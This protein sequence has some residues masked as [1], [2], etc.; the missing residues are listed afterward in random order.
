MDHHICTLEEVRN[1]APSRRCICRPQVLC[2]GTNSIV[3]HSLWS[4]EIFDQ[5]VMYA[6]RE[7]RG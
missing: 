4:A 2:F 1:H 6:F 7:G 5:A 3:V